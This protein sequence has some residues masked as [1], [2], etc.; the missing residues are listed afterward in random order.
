MEMDDIRILFPQLNEKV[1][2][3]PLVYLDNAATS[4]RPAT[5]LDKW[6]EMIK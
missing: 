2:N 5:V 4:L 1:Y 6:M 3:K